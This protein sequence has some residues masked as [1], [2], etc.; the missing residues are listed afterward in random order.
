MV[1]QYQMRYNIAILEFIAYIVPCDL[2]TIKRGT[3]V[4]VHIQGD[5]KLESHHL[6]IYVY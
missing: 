5:Q 1:L 4:F 3:L 6:R 2:V